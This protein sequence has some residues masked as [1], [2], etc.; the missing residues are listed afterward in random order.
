[1]KIKILR[2]DLVWVAL[3]AFFL[4]VSCHHDGKNSASGTPS[5]DSLPALF[6]RVPAASSGISF[7]N[8]LVETDKMNVLTYQYLYNGAGVAIGDIDNDGLPDIFFAA[9]T[10]TCRLYKNNGNFH[11]TDITE[12]AGIHTT[13]WCQGVTMAD[14]NNDG[15]LD[16]YV[17][18]SS[19]FETPENRRNLLFI[20][21]RNGTFTEK[22]KSYGLDNDGYS[23][24]A[25][26]FDYDHDGDLDMYLVNHGTDFNLSLIGFTNRNTRI[27]P[28]ITHRLYRNN[29]NN[30]FTDVSRE[31]GVLCNTFGLSATVCDVNN[32][33]WEDIYVT[34]DFAMPDFL[35][36]NNKNGKFT[37]SCQ[38]M[39]RHMPYFSMGS[40]VADINNDGWQDIMT[41]DMVPEDNRRQKMLFGFQNFDKYQIMI[42]E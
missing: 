4:D 34:N 11:F 22:A 24:H 39:I 13:G 27:D 38:K 1:M 28:Y 2:T 3:V 14:V 23:T 36:I 12:Q 16:I 15:F 30:T 37:E 18:R 6:S 21:N 19:T 33:G 7:V 40:D 10:T 32:D 31:A 8:T 26:F 17:C 5:K 20:N 42:K 9:N 29:G 35:Y 25:T 41:L